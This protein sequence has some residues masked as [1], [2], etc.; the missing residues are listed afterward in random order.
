MT[1]PSDWRAPDSYELHILDDGNAELVGQT[2][3]ERILT[4]TLVDVER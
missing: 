3:L 1:E 2:A 4:D